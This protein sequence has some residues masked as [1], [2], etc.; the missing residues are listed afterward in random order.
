MYELMVILKPL[1]PDDVRKSIHKNIVKT[2]Q[3]MGGDVKD[4]D[5][6]GKRYL[7]YDIK[8]HNEGYYIVY[9]YDLPSNQVEEFA[10]Q[11]GLK[12]EVIRFLVTV[13]EH[14]SDIK[15]NIKKKEMDI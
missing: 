14:A 11:L 1:L 13:V 12:Q 8:G 15:K 3:D 7:A 10:R 2:I 5:V 9:Q 6:W 4:V